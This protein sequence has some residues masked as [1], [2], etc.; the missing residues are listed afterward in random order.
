MNSSARISSEIADSIR[1][2]FDSFDGKRVIFASNYYPP[3][4]LGGAEI[5]AH[6]QAKAML[7]DGTVKGVSFSLEMTDSK[8]PGSVIYEEYEG[9][10]VIRVVVYS[11]IAESN[12]INFYNRDI[13]EVFE[14]LCKLIKPDVVHCH[15]L[16]GMS[17]GIIDV[18][19]NLNIRT[20]ITLHDNWGFCYKNI[21][22]DNFGV[23]CKDFYNCSCCRDAITYKGIHIPIGL[24][25]AYIKRT[26]SKA[27][28]Y[29]SPSRYLADT[30]VS[31]GFDSSKMNVISNGIDVDRF[32]SVK[33]NPSSK[34]RIT[35]IAYF[36]NHKGIDY[37]IKAL[38]LLKRD[39]V[40]I[41]LVGSGEEENTYRILAKEY[42]ITDQIKIWG[43]IDNSKI[44]E[45]YAE[46][47]I[48]CLPSKWPEN[49]PVSIT[50]AMACSI[51]VVASNIGGI[52]ELVEDGVTGFLFEPQNAES[53]KEKLELLIDDPELRK[54]M[55]DNGF[56]KISEYS[57]ESQVRKISKL[58]DEIES[59]SSKCNKIIAVKGRKLPSEISSITDKD[60][61]LW[62]WMNFDEDKKDIVA[63][64]VT[65]G[66]SLNR[67]ELDFC[68]DNNVA[69][70]ADLTDCITLFGKGMT[71]IPYAGYDDMFNA[72]SKII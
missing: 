4:C 16:I 10:I 56:K 11:D 23:F 57:F 64:I 51:P 21:L 50:E 41:N 40:V 49:Q 60:V 55:G 38:A 37:L 72:V 22:L 25:R 54:K 42:G 13:N 24:R 26:V 31:A 5:I 14:E 7:K 30:Y 9:I 17:L 2:Y 12:R 8:T 19:R 35:V 48:Y 20:C 52:G 61:L 27:D 28:C 18:A 34:I 29:I 45:V 39:D 46:T 66:Y 69:I 59:K 71:V 68:K 44:S 33:K 32:S 47:D 15:N 62:D 43:R 53:L 6:N 1:K 3:K 70:I 65:R 67:S 58:Y 63:V 36:G